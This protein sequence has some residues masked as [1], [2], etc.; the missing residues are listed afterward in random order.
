MQTFILYAIFVT[1]SDHFPEMSSQ[2][3]IKLSFFVDR[4]DLTHFD[5]ILNENLR[6]D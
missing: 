4:C 2:F 5:S 3:E 1:S 6:G